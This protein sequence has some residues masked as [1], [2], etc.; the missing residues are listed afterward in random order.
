MVPVLRGKS[1]LFDERVRLSNVHRSVVIRADH[2]A[3]RA[4]QINQE[5]QSLRIESECVVVKAPDVFPER[6]RQLEL[7][8]DQTALDSSADI[9]KAS[10]G[11]RQHDFQIWKFVERACDNKFSGGGVALKSKSQRII[12]VGRLRQRISQPL[13]TRINIVVAIEGMK[14]QGISQLLNPREHRL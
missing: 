7:F 6:A 14:Q 13:F 8:V 12:D 1:N 9:G 5:P 10:S 4:D 11:M 3:V 2:N